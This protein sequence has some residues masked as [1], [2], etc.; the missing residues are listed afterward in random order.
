MSRVEDYGIYLLGHEG[1]YAIHS[2]GRDADACC[3]AQ[4]SLSILAGIRVILE[5]GD[6]AVG[7]KSYK[8]AVVVDYRELLN[9]VCEEYL[10]CRL[11]ILLVSGDY[12]LL[13]HHLVDKARHI[14][15]ES[16]VAVRNDAYEHT[17][18]IYYR[19]ATDLILLHQLQRIAYGVGLEDGHRVVDHTALGTLYATHVCRLS[20]YRHILVNNAY[21][22]FAS[23]GYGQRGLR[24]GVHSCGHDRYVKCDISRETTLCRDLARQNLRIGWYEQH[25]VECQTCWQYPFIDK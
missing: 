2:I 12:V 22:A 10:G 20:R 5:L 4:T 9:L 6:I 19:D 21:T 18:V 1:S 7:D 16:Q 13:S 11:K 15:L 25:I 8:F 23:E 14:A 3:Y 24:Y 17:L